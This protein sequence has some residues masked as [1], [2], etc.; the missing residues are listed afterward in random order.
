MTRRLHLTNTLKKD[1]QMKGKTLYINDLDGT[2]LNSSAELS[3]FSRR[4]LETLCGRGVNISAATARTAATAVSLL[5]GTGI[6]IP[7]VLMNGVCVFDLQK[8][9]Y[10][11]VFPMQDEAKR[12]ALRT[13]HACGLSGFLYEIDGV[14]LCTYYENLS[15]PR[16]ADFMRTR[17][18]KYGKVFIKVGSFDEVIDRPLV[19]Y[20]VSDTQKKT[21]PAAE[22]LG[23]ETGLRCEYYK[24]IYED[25]CF[26]LEICDT[27]A[28]KK[29][30][31]DFLKKRFGFDRVV[32]FGDNY[33]D[34]PL[35]EACDE[36][37]A[38]E[39]AVDLIK[40]R[41]DG[42]IEANNADGVVKFLL[43]KGV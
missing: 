17:Q 28:S 14:K 27:N 36:F 24:D 38:V 37:Y 41:A 22:A 39:N 21:Q 12:A 25:D 42:I 23:N 10:V 3:D 18:E 8:K 7:V 29:T 35:L 1:G 2:L 34:L 30:A 33:N 11:R 31:V 6:N 5:D 13:I 40:E 16:A 15:S 43:E 9:E 32:G 4:G 26:Y 20:S 19:Y